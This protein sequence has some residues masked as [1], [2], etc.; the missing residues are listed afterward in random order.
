MGIL[1]KFSEGSAQTIKIDEGTLNW[2]QC[3]RMTFSGTCCI[4]KCGSV[5]A[6]FEVKRDLCLTRTSNIRSDFR[7]VRIGVVYFENGTFYLTR[8]HNFVSKLAP[9][10]AIFTMR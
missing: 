9:T 3:F 6:A 2:L 5:T 10:T 7:N 1:L 4:C 8:K